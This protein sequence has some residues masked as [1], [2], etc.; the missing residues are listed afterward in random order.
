MAKKF[1]RG[2]AML[3]VLATLF[4]VISVG[5]FA[6]EANFPIDKTANG[7]DAN[8]QTD[9]TLTVPGAF[10]GNIDVVFILGGGMPENMETIQSAIESCGLRPDVRGERLT[11]QD[12]ANLA[13]ALAIRKK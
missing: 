4:S 10:E 3:L 13:S 1:A 11:L 6:A 12:F 7:L 9:V 5:A 8:D 2:L